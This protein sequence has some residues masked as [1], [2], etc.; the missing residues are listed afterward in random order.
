MELANHINAT[1]R[2]GIGFRDVPWRLTDVLLVLAPF[3]LII[4]TGFG[5]LTNQI[6]PSPNHGD[7]LAWLIPTLL[8]QGFSLIVPLWIAIRRIGI[9]MPPSVD[10]IREDA[11]YSMWL[12]PPCL[13]LI[14]FFT[15]GIVHLLGTASHPSDELSI[16]L[17]H[18]YLAWQTAFAVIIAPICEEIFFR[19]MIFNALKRILP[20]WAAI[21]IQATIFGLFHGRDAATLIPI[22]LAGIIFSLVYE[23]K[24]R[25][26]ASIALH[27]A[28]NLISTA[29]LWKVYA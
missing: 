13:L 4:L 12:A 18:A 1:A 10:E 8:F 16:R 3:A 7:R 15:G 23:R 28:C 11:N 19:G 27:A 29:A 22:G 14:V 25:L 21:I 20:M 17:D 2:N 26:T 24:Q 5:T 9:P 6:V